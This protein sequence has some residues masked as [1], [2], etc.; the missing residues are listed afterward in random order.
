MNPF[1]ESTVAR[2]LTD[3]EMAVTRTA[4][5]TCLPLI[6][7][8]H[9]SRPAS[10]LR[11][12]RPF[13]RPVVGAIGLAAGLAL[14]GTAYAVDANAATQAQLESVRGIGPKT[15][16]IIIEERVRGGKYESFD[17]LS[18][19]VKGIGPKKA[20]T[21]QAA[22]LTVGAAGGVSAITAGAV[23]LVSAGDAKSQAGS[24]A[25][26]GKNKPARKPAGKPAK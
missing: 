22:G 8:S 19:R 10:R 4:A 18:E 7:G 14:S 21:L 23:P 16:Q 17:D 5:K 12:T 11:P 2:P 26:S 15:A 25:L 3:K 6:H 13:W 24:S 20:A 9:S 1:T